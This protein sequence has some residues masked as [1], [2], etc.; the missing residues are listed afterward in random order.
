V[1][2]LSKSMYCFS[3]QA[4]CSLASSSSP[5]GRKRLAPSPEPPVAVKKRG[6]TATAAP[7]SLSVNPNDAFVEAVFT[8]FPV[9]RYLVVEAM[10]VEDSAIDLT[11]L[12]DAL[13]GPYASADDPYLSDE[14]DDLSGAA[15]VELGTKC[16]NVCARSGGVTVLRWGRIVRSNPQYN[17]QAHLFPVGFRSQRIYW[18]PSP[19]QRTLYQCDIRPG[20]PSPSR[21]SHGGPSS[22]GAVGSSVGPLFVITNVANPALTFQGASADGKL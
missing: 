5:K 11:A 7:S 10:S 1:F 3:D 4:E 15:L 16:T 8:G 6:R 14:D 21:L 13:K 17:T 18:G 19:L 2:N 22:V 12:P 9:Q 20:K